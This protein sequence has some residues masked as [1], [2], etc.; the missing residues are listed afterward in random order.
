MGD[1]EG[2]E[3]VDIIEVV[4]GMGNDSEISG[5]PGVDDGLIDPTSDY[6][7]DFDAGFFGEGE[8]VLWRPSIPDG[9]ESVKDGLPGVDFHGPVKHFGVVNLDDEAIEKGFVDGS[10]EFDYLVKL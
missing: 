7:N 5:F 6:G 1:A 3:A 9:V 8:D 10:G 2:I 4:N